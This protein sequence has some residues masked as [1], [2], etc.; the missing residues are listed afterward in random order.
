MYLKR[1]VAR[2]FQHLKDVCINLASDAVIFVGANNSGQDISNTF[3]SAF[4]ENNQ[5]ERRAS[6]MESCI[7][8]WRSCRNTM[9]PA[10]LADERWVEAP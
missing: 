1:F 10:L 3:L 4:T 9:A 7:L 5:D 8:D 2:S 6:L